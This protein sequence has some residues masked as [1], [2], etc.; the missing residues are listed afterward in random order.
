MRCVF[1]AYIFNE[2]P[3]VGNVDKD[4][5]L[6]DT[7]SDKM[8]GLLKISSTEWGWLNLRA[9]FC[10]EG[11]QTQFRFKCVPAPSLTPNTVYKELNNMTNGY[12]YTA[13]RL[14]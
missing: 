1:E 3:G 14:Q 10:L 11:K 4:T 5:P 2:D 8:K 7:S 6:R 13:D 12:F 9:L